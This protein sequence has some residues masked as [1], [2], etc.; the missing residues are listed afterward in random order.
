MWRSRVQFFLKHN[1][2]QDMF[3]SCKI[4]WDPRRC[5]Y[6]ISRRNHSLTASTVGKMLRAEIVC[7]ETNYGKNLSRKSKKAHT[8][9]LL[10]C[11]NPVLTTIHTGTND[12][13]I[14]KPPINDETS[15]AEVVRSWVGKPLII[16]KQKSKDIIINK[17]I[18]LRLGAF[19]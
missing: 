3:G 5:E 8:F 18:W 16:P 4:L 9:E 15:A 17:T 2:N 6:E 13:H 10:Y 12:T 11:N 7:T 19:G 1:W 14:S